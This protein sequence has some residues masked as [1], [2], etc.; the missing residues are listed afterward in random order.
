[1]TAFTDAAFSLSYSP[2]VISKYVSS[3]EQELAQNYRARQ[4][5]KRAEPD[6]EGRV[7]DSEYPQ[8]N[9]D[10]QRM[11]ELSRQLKGSFE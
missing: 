3:I 1:M 6:A 11:M 2:S 7:A 4:Q 8:A 10:Y 5:V 9:T